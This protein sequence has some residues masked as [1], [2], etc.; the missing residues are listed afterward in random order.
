M[1]RLAEAIQ[2]A[3]LRRCGCCG[4]HL[5]ATDVAE[6]GVTPGVFICA[7][8]ALWAARRAGL[9]S[10]LRQIRVRSLLPRFTRRAPHTARAAIPILASSDQD[11][12]AAFYAPVGFVEAE[13]HDGY[14][15]LHDDGVELH[16]TYHDTITPAPASCTSPTPRSCGNSFANSTSTPSATSP[17]RTTGCA[18]SRLPTRTATRYASA[19]RAP[20]EDDRSRFPQQ[21][22]MMRLGAQLTAA[23]PM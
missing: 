21:S 15:L 3:D 16:F 6:L 23:C 5:P 19:A 18:S 8:C 20:T 12:T 17:I 4:R 14:L 7:G 22:P 13:R 2:A 1:T 10:A 11:R 9:L